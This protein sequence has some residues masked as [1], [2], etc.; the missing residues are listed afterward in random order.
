M[1]IGALGEFELIKR[2]FA[3]PEIA[4]IQGKYTGDLLGI[5]DD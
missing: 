5:G 2:Y 3:R 1:A 4:Q